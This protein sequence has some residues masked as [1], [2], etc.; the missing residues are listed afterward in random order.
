MKRFILLSLALSFF[1]GIAF[2]DNPMQVVDKHKNLQI[3]GIP[4]KTDAYPDDALAKDV[5]SIG[6]PDWFTKMSKAQ[7]NL[8]TQIVTMLRK[9]QYEASRA[10]FKNFLS[11]LSAS[12]FTYNVNDRIGPRTGKRDQ[13]I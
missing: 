2:A 7:K 9:E 12:G 6:K 3:F 1:A 8:A 11:S 10:A 4:Q 13:E 5:A